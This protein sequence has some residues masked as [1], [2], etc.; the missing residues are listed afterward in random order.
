MR[1]L[2]TYIVKD[3]MNSRVLKTNILK[4][5]KIDRNTL[6]ILK[7][8]EANITRNTVLNRE[9]SPTL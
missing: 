8:I 5:E 2:A 4:Q 3:L 1:T 7:I 9:D 6:E